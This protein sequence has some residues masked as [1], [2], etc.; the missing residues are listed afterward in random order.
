[1]DIP[2]PEWKTI[3]SKCSKSCGGG[4][5]RYDIL[6]IHINDILTITPY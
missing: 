4:T 6:M 3:Y 2:C 1:M 5:L